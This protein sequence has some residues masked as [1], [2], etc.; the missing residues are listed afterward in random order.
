MHYLH[1]ILVHIP[2]AV[3]DLDGMSQEELLD[4]V[5]T[6]AENETESYYGQAFD[7]RETASAG[8]W[9][10]S[11]PVNVLLA[12]NDPALF[13]EELD[14]CQQIQR[15]EINASLQEL[16]KTVGTD[17]VQIADGI[18]EH[19]WEDEPNRGFTFM[20]AYYLHNLASLLYGTYYADS[21]FYN[22]HGCTARLYR[23]DMEAVREKSENWALVV[24]DYHN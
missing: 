14:H 1:K 5:R 13:M 2:D 19:N 20:T 18:W 22:A 8:R 6:H 21:C 12:S 11:Y 24:F 17:L 4:A 15:M 10:N 3:A 9:S 23:S 7:W 16:K